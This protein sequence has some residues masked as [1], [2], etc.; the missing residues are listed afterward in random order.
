M[1]NNLYY[2]IV[3]LVAYNKQLKSQNVKLKPTRN[4]IIDTVM[5]DDKEISIHYIPDINKMGVGFI[6]LMKFMNKPYILVDD[7]Y[8]AVPELLQKAMVYHEI[9]HYVHGDLNRSIKDVWEQ[10]VFLGK[11]QCASPEE[12]NLLVASTIHTRDYTQELLA[13]QYAVEHCGEDAVVAVLRTL[14]AIIP[15]KREIN[16]RFK[17]ITGNEL[18]H[19]SVFYSLLEK[20]E[21][22]SLSLLLDDED[23]EE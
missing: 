22:I 14:S 16:A 19:D 20:A 1:R 3:G 15:D 7:R 4:N 12:R 9:G 5:V 17:A 2:A 23:D 11:V 18:E 13:D 8:M 10:L 6:G 21:T